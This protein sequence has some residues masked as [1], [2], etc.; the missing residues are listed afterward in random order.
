[1][2]FTV[3]QIAALLNGEVVGNTNDI[4]K[5]F[6]K[7]EEGREGTLSFLSNTKYINHLYDSEATAILI[8]KDI[9][10]S[11]PVKA[12]LIKVED[13]YQALATLT[14]LYVSSLPR[15]K[16]IE[17]PSYIS[18][19][20]TLGSDCYVGAFAYIGENAQI[21]DN[22]LIYPQA[23]IGDNV[24]IGDNTI[25]YSGVKLYESSQIGKNCILHSGCVIGADGFGFAKQEDG[26]YKKLH[27]LG[28]VVLGD[29]V[30]IG[31]NTTIDCATMGST[32]IKNGVKLDDQVMIGHNVVVGEN[33]VMAA[34]VGIAGSTVVGDNCVFGGQ[35]GVSG[36]IKIGNNVTAGGKAG[37]PN[38]LK[39]GVIVMGEVGMEFRKFAR[40]NSIYRNLPELWADV[41][42]IKKQLKNK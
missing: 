2:E 32:I 17:Q 20:S 9:E 34:Q 19:N 13:A 1:M 23:Y 35:V 27:Q 41:R 15:K 37:I 14:D 18:I 22:V 29:D 4:L 16:G 30:E 6:S 42:E 10:I 12:T 7:I 24:K 31:A 36:H 5:S 8:N 11:K 26:V 39:D 3:G 28:N 21:G 25:V 38:N 40:I 33:T